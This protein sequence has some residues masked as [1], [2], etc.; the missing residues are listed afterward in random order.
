MLDH[1]QSHLQSPN[2]WTYINIGNISNIEYPRE[3]YFKNIL[4]FFYNNIICRLYKYMIHLDKFHFSL[5]L[6]LFRITPL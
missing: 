4:F 6:S 5:S 3:Y 2:V 1:L